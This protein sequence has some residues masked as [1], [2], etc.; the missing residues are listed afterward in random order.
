[1]E[2]RYG[3]LPTNWSYA[4]GE[5]TTGLWRMQRK[6]IEMSFFKKAA[7][8]AVAMSLTAAPAM[9][10]SNSASQLSLASSA[11]A[12]KVVAEK[13][14]LTG[15]G[16]IVAIAAAAAVIAGIVIVADSDDTPDSP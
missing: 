5:P 13:D 9:A 14:K 4:I 6:G 8:A 11:R 7:I 16:V 10:A 15:A 1:M 2:C 3:A 12:G